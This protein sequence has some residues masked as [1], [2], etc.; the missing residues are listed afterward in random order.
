MGKQMISKQC[1]WRGCD[2][3]FKTPVSEVKRGNGKYHS[4]SCST[5][6]RN[7]KAGRPVGCVGMD[8][9]GSNNGNWKG[10]RRIHTKGYVEIHKPGHPRA[11]PNGY[12]L[13]HLIVMEKKLGRPLADGEIVH[14]KDQDKQNNRPNNLA[15]TDY[16]EHNRTHLQRIH[17]EEVRRLKAD[18]LTLGEV[19]ETIGVKPNS[20]YRALKRR[21]QRFCNL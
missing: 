15:L 17:V 11:Q 9:A 8:S 2:I 5:K 7:E 19:A 6:A 10:G 20:V 4:R 3:T 13:E 16:P 21:G 18:G 12:V 14:H 1:E